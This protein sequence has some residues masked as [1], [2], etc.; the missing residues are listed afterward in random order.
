LPLIIIIITIAFSIVVYLNAIITAPLTSHPGNLL[1]TDEGKLCLLDFGLCAAVDEKS[2]KAMT[3]AILHL[4]LRDFDSLVD[5]SAVEL[6]F[7]PNGYDTSQLKP[8]IAKILTVGLLDNGSSNFFHRKRKLLEISN[9]LNEV[10]FHYPFSVPPFF[11]LVTRGLGLL[12]GIA[13]TGD[14][15]FDIFRASAPYARRHAM[16]IIGS[17]RLTQRQ[18]Q[19]WWHLY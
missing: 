8:V 14:P 10:F 15:N 13:L 7:L 1:V 11:A 4:L 19:A 12:E 9:E 3:K 5:Q 6:G 2:R 16:R 18:K 17:R